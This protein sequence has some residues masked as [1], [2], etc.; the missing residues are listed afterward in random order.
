MARVFV[1]VVVVVVGFGEGLI[2]LG[3]SSPLSY[4]GVVISRMCYKNW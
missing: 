4:V 1:C 3:F 2:V